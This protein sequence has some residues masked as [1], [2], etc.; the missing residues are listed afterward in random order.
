MKLSHL[1][2]VV[3]L[4]L[5]LILTTA[6]AHAQVGLYLNPIAT[7][8]GNSG[9]AQDSSPY[10]FLGPNDTSR[11]FFGA[12]LGG[13]YDFYHSG[14]FGAGA[15]IR[16]T[17]QHANNASLKEFLVGVRFTDK[18]F[19]RPF[20]PYLQASIGGGWTKSPTS[21]ISIKKVNYRFSIGGDYTIHKHVDFRM[22]EVGYGA[23]DVISS[24]TVGG[25][26]DVAVPASNM[27]TVSSGLVFRF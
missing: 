8:V 18:P 11:T 23:L 3:S 4:A 16:W 9:L 7:H 25:G 20:K 26:G 17:D 13:Y 21:Q 19:A 24:A 6:A 10:A 2:T 1:A 14:K 22:I 5:T 12:T 15:D 27:I